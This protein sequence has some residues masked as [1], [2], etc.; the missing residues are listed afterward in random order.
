MTPGPLDKADLRLLTE[1]GFLGA[2]ANLPR[3]VSQLFSALMELR[4]RRAFS[5]VGLA[6]A[7]LNQSRAD[8]ALQVMQQGVR[9]LDNP[10]PDDALD[11]STFDP[12][13]DP[14]MMHTFHGLCLLANQR[15][16]EAQQVL[17]RVLQLP[18]YPPAL[19]LA[20]GLL[21]LRP[22]AHDTKESA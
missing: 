3:P 10:L 13:Q 12:V 17:Q 20:R 7:H 2:G 19:R 14:A 22:E 18:E 15:T 8:S 1:I 5:Y 16:A 11:A 4:P 6:T 9:M 21:G